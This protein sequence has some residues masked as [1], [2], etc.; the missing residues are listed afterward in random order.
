MFKNRKLFYIVLIVALAAVFYYEHR[1]LDSNLSHLESDSMLSKDKNAAATNPLGITKIENSGAASNTALGA[2]SDSTAPT[3][4]N[5]PTWFS[6]EA[7]NLE[8]NTKDPA[9]KEALLKA[10]AQQLTPAEINFLQKKATDAKATANERISATYLLTLSASAQ[11]LVEISQSPLSLPSPQPVHSIG[12]TLLMQ[13]KAIRVMAIDELFN[14]VK[15]D[16]TL[17]N[18]LLTLIN[19]ISDEGVKQYALKRYHELK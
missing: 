8:A 11:S 5:F 16:A 1:K 4:A 3:T 9:E 19:K 2:E 18:Q 13:E 7:K 12:E 14:R 10:K 6:E 17:R 15:T